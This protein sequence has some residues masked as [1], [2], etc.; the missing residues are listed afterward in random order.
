[1][2]TKHDANHDPHKTLRHK[3]SKDRNPQY[4]N[5]EL[6]TAVT[7][8]VATFCDTQLPPSDRVFNDSLQ[9]CKLRS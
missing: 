7:A 3:F 9:L 2:N 6:Q 1:M 5:L 8:R 4:E